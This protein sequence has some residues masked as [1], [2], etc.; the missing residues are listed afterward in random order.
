MFFNLKPSIISV[1]ILLFQFGIIT[2]QQ[3][4]VP[5]SLEEA[6]GRT[7]ENNRQIKVADFEYMAALSDV[8]K[9]KSI[10]L[11]QVEASAMG[12]AN[13][14]PLQ[15]FG[16]KLQQGAIGQ[17]DF[18]PASLNSPSSISNLQT[19]LM[20]RQPIL[21]MDAKAMKE[22]VVAKSNAYSQQAV[23]TKKVLR[24]QVAQAYL[25][26]QLTYNMVEVLEKAKQTAEANL[27]LTK[28]NMEAGYVQHA[29]VLFV[30]VRVNEIDNQLF[31]TKSN[32]Q[33]ISDQLSFLMGEGYGKQYMPVDKLTDMDA[34]QILMEKLPANRS[35]IKAMEMQVE[36]QKHMLSAAQKTSLPRVNA[37]G[38]YELNNNLDFADSQHGYLLGVQASWQI[39]NGNKNKSAVNK[40][41][42]EIEKSQ[43]QLSQLI[44]QNNLEYEMAKRKMLEARNKIELTEKAIE[45]SKESLRIKTDRYAEGLEKTADILMAET[46]VSQKEMDYIEAIYQY[47]LAYS[48]ILLMLE[49]N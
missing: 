2:A 29:D 46:K 44:A 10:Y 5:L 21:N 48:Q 18:I 47:Q 17:S 25:Q 40:A 6:I 33:N 3:A 31:Q 24:F 37:F 23:R 35:D 49:K 11:P 30:E 12:S 28:D 22:A 43:M 38:S 16:T 34:S 14:L 4:V 32:I 41:K 39:F 1:F 13:N 20:V 36:A 15:S 7:M 27:K 42:I 9:M 26:L 45:Q 19:Q 8:D